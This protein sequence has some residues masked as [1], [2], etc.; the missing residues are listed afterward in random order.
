MHI[1]LLR[2]LV[3]FFFFFL[4][5]H[6]SIAI[7]TASYKKRHEAALFGYVSEFIREVIN[8][9]LCL[10]DLLHLFLYYGHEC[11]YPYPASELCVQ[12]HFSEVWPLACMFPWDVY[13]IKVQT[14]KIL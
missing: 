9:G 1:Q 14:E 4:T 11:C 7:H 8:S 10:L 5:F 6:R 2:M 12:L 13:G 3:T